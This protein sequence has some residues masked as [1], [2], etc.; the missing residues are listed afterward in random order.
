MRYRCRRAGQGLA[1][2]GGRLTIP[3]CP[4]RGLGAFTADDADVFVGREDEI[5]RLREMV[6]RQPLVVVNGPSGVGK[7]SLV[8][9]GLIPLLRDQGWAAGSFR[10]GGMPV[11]ALARALAA[12][13]VPGRPPTVSE[14]GEWA[15]LIRSQGWASGSTARAGARPVRC[16]CTRTSWKRSWTRRHARRTEG[17]VPG[18]AAVSAAVPDDG[19][20]LVGTLR[21]DFWTQLLEHPDAGARLADGGSGCPR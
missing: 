7:S 14:V 4:Y 12:V 10:P 17:R 2:C 3:A 20:H 15:A 9:A 18:S 5:G 19:L 21:A 8:N 13:Q 11:D 6:R 1:R 16:C